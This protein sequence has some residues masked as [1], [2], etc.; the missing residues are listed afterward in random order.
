M[1]GTGRRRHRLVV[2]LPSEPGKRTHRLV[3]ALLS[4]ELKGGLRDVTFMTVLTK[5]LKEAERP[6]GPPPGT[7]AGAGGREAGIPLRVGMV[8][9]QYGVVPA[10]YSTLGTPRTYSR[11]RRRTEQHPRTAG[12]GGGGPGLSPSCLAWVA[13]LWSPWSPSVC[14]VSSVEEAS[15]S[16]LLLVE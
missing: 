8:P 7:S 12:A 2:V 1:C 14:L 3:T 5:L 13:A 4:K 15:A 10:Q 16:R 6:P 11:S 9:A